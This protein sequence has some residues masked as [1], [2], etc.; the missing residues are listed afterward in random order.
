MFVTIRQTQA[1]GKNLF[2]VEGERGILFRARTPWADIQIPCQV[3]NLRELTFSDANGNEVFH[4][5]YN[6]VENTMQ[7]LSRYKYLF[8]TATKLGEYQVVGPDGTVHGS[9]YTQIDGAFTTQMTIDC[10]DRTYDCYARSL[11]K[12]YVI[13]VFDGERQIA[14]ITKPLD[15]WDRLDIYYLHL[16]DG[17]RSLL[18]ILSFFT[19]YVDAQK[20][21]RPGQITAYSVEKSWSY[22]FDKNNDRY[23]PDWIRRTFGQG[24]ADHLDY[25]LKK[26]PEKRSVDPERAKRN[27]R[28]IIGILVAVGLVLV[29]VVAALAWMLL[30]P[31]TALSPAEFAAQ[32]SGYGYTVTEGA[33]SGV[34]DSWELSYEARVEDYSLEYLSFPSETAAEQFFVQ[35]KGLLAER[36]QGTHMETSTNLINSQKY[37]LTAGGTYCALSRVDDTVILCAAPEADKNEIK[38]I[39]KE[40]GY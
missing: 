26:H 7:A 5:T 32:M 12:I 39:L 15:V 21:N 16:D 33:P 1:N 9:F 31:K 22:S 36:Q 20:V 29:I 30:R 38:E 17:Y 28:L 6:I 2:Q 27:R 40:L 34:E 11:G 23:D 37:T 13:S 3:E 19:I 4:T 25:L 8:G 10:R 14:Q 24:A 18:P 35:M